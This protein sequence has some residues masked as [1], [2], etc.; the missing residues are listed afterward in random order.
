MKSSNYK[1][2]VAYVIDIIIVT[3]IS[4]FLTIN[5]YNGE[6]YQDATNQYTTLIQE[7]TNKEINQ[8]EYLKKTNDIVYTMNKES[9]AISIVTEVMTIISFVVVPYFMN[10][11]TFGKKIM[12]LKIVCNSN[13]TISMN[14]YLVRSLFINSILMN[15]LS[16]ITILFLNKNTY[17]IINDITTYLFGMIYIVSIIMI[18]FRKDSR[19]LHDLIANT[20][21]I[22]INKTKEYVSDFEDEK[23]DNEDSKLKDAEIIGEKN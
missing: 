10:G 11:Q 18:S 13:K 20:K 12:K 22:D 19:G 17:L 15:I 21:V 14:N 1:R 8:E 6:K 7:Y 5:I 23:K 3:V 16:I 4:T 9:I 2:I